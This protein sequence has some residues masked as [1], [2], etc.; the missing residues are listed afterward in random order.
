M[1]YLT[2]ALLLVVV[3]GCGRDEAAAPP[4]P[5]V[6]VGQPVVKTVQE[7]WIFTGVTRAVESAEIH[8]RVSG[9]LEEMHFEPSH[10]VEKDA[11]LFTIEQ[12]YYRAVRDEARAAVKAA[13][14]DLALAESELERISRAIE[15][16]AVSEMDL[17]RARAER[18]KA[19]AS[20][21]NAQANLS[22][23][24]LDYSYTEVRAPFGGL[25]SRNLV[26]LGNLVGEGQETHLTTV[27][28]MQP[29]FIYFDVPEAN[30]LERLEE[31]DQT[32]VKDDSPRRV[33]TEAYIAT[34][35]DK[36]FPHLAILDYTDNTVNPQTG[37]IQVRAIYPNE[38]NRLFPGLFVRVKVMGMLL[39]NSVM[40]S[41]RALG[42]DL[43]GRFVLLIGEDNIVEQRYVT[44]DDLVVD[45]M[46]RIAEGL[47]GNETYIVEGL[48]KARPGRPVTPLTPEQAQ[49]KQQAMQK[50]QGA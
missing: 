36:E 3:A 44:P 5:L 2:F 35:A 30:L 40:I 27:K 4:P 45:G 41:E 10:M 29:I 39:E 19:D 49:Q 14:A 8:A 46:I 43:G 24:E 48:Q 12:E 33:I 50:T 13:E 28:K 9:I 15:T 38:N 42:T 20:V 34:A 17:D 16:N 1:R 25:V 32:V 23:A 21:L 18:D 7:Y 22:K 11:L 31:T 26:D 47:E 6:I 37:T